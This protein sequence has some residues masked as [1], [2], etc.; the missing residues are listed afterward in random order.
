MQ[1]HEE[2]KKKFLQLKE[3]AAKYNLNLHDIDKVIDSME[4]F[5]VTSPV[6]GN[7][8]TGKS[9]LINAILGKQL[10]SVDVTPETAV[11]ME[12]Y[13]GHNHVYRYYKDSVTTHSIDELPLT[14]LTIHN[15]DVVQIEYD[16]EFL[17]SIDRVKIVDLPGFDTSIELHNKAIDDYLPNS[18]AYLLVV[19]SDEPILK[20]SITELL[21]E[22]KLH[23]VPVYLILTKCQRLSA[24]ELN[25]YR[26]MLSNYVCGILG[27]SDV[28]TACTESYGEIQV[29]EVKLFLQEIQS[30][31]SI[32]FHNKYSEQLKKAARYTEVYLVE[33]IDKKDLSTS[34]LEL[35]AERLKKKIDMLME[36]IDKEMKNF[37]GQMNQ[38]ILA[39][40]G[41]I[42]E[43]MLD[44]QE[45]IAVMIRN[46]KDIRDRM[47]IVIRNAIIVSLKAEFEPRL[48]H[49]LQSVAEI[50]RQDMVS[51]ESFMVDVEDAFKNDIIQDNISLFT[52][53]VLGVVGIAMGPV[54]P[55]IGLAIGSFADVLMNK[56]SEQKKER[57]ALKIADELIDKI[58]I[59]AAEAASDQIRSYV[60]DINEQIR[61]KVLRQREILI[62]SLDD[63]KDE[64]CLEEHQK[65]SDISGM[66]S[67][68]ETIREFMKIE[69]L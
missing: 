39:L 67:D 55:I 16:H 53:F 41:K 45:A 57:K 43:T 18:L 5:R 54:G 3:I 60:D 37:E 40:H 23:N 12:I 47:S 34:E 52:P 17:K 24:E 61:D 48:Y 33:R 7:F 26:N 14:D 1:Y 51:N 42:R 11:P 19:S 68:L 4:T 20:S 15:T 2:M 29:E 9:S 62:K 8:S 21:K 56:M 46:G 65:Q 38:C 27:T 10:V 44:A 36:D 66:M 63:V 69:L 22:L 28:K 31:T 50:I 13:Y 64:L 32:L 49:Y 58:S 25:E 6:I 59:Q 35:E 30:Q